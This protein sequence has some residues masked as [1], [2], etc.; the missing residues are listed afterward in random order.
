MSIPVLGTAIVN[1][2]HWLD[3][4]IQSVDY[5]VDNFVV[6]NNNGRGQIT[7]ELDE[8]ASRPHP[9]IKQ[10]HICHLPH[11]I[12]CAGAWNMIIKSFITAPYW[13]IANHDLQFGPGMLE[14]MVSKANDPEVGMVHCSASGEYVGDDISRN[15]GSF[16]CFLLKDWVVEK[17]GLFDENIYPGYCEDVDYILRIVNNPFKRLVTNVPYLHGEVNYASTGSQTWRND[18]SLKQKIDI[19]HYFNREYIFSKWGCFWDEKWE[20]MNPYKTPFNIPNI[21]DVKYNISIPRKNNLGF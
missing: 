11:N 9:F 16:E 12:G 6:F 3:R 1:G 17:I 8:L 2:V 13:I 20:N 15:L 18:V 5:P 7:K 19:A 14:S 21:S 4:L 10:F